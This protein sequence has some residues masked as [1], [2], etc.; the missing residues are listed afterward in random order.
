MSILYCAALLEFGYGKPAFITVSVT[1]VLND[2][3]NV[4]AMVFRQENRGFCVL[5]ARR[6]SNEDLRLRGKKLALRENVIIV[7]H[8]MENNS[9]DNS[10]KEKK[11]SHLSVDVRVRVV[12]PS[13]ATEM[14]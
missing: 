4:L 1:G 6:T 7:V 12:W 3:E 8:Y 11:L 14:T 10:Q 5:T 2:G 9:S 13:A